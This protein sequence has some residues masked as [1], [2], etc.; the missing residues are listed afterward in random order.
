[1]S[2]PELP[3]SKPRPKLEINFDDEPD[4]PPYAP[5]PPGR[6]PPVPAPA[7]L[8]PKPA[9][10]PVVSGYEHP[11]PQ[12]ASPGYAN[13]AMAVAAMSMNRKSPGTAVLLSLLFTGAGQVYCGRAARGI[14]FFGAAF[15]SAILILA[16]V[17]FI[18]LPMVW[19]W[20]AI[21]AANLASKQNAT[22]VAA[23]A[24][25]PPHPSSF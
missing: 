3:P 11:P 17:G 9:P 22:L 15:V 14:A 18:L 23:M 16:L 20:A 2:N 25:Q 24:G 13:N 1:M 7:A 6:R 12:A 21:D 4:P 10:L 5:A 8:D 19:I